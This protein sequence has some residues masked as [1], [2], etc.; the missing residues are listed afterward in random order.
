[1]KSVRPSDKPQSHEER[2]AGNPF[3]G[4]YV[5]RGP[6]QE[7]RNPFFQRRACMRAGG[8]MDHDFPRAGLLETS[9]PLKG[10]V[11][12]TLALSGLIG[13]ALLAFTIPTMAENPDAGL[14]LSIKSA[15]GGPPDLSVVQNLSLFV[16]AGRAASPF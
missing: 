9:P 2:R 10:F 1:M 16:P 14:I 6:S 11:G 7:L 3:R 12:K 8:K 4:S 15:N 13:S 5:Y